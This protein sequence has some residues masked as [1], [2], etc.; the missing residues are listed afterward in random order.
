MMVERLAAALARTD[1]TALERSLEGE[2][3]HPG[4]PEY[5]RSRRLFNA[6]V[7][8][9]PALI[10][11]CTGPEDV[12]LAVGF[13]RKHAVPLS[14]K[15]GGHGVSGGALCDD[16]ITLD[17][18]L[19]DEVEV[20]EDERRARCG[21]GA[22]WERLND[23]AL[24]RGLV[25]AG[26]ACPSVG[27]AGSTLGGGLGPLMGRYGLSC[28][29]LL[30]AE[31]VTS[32]GETVRASR[33][34]ERELLWG[35]RGGGGN[36]GAVTSMELRLHPADEVYGGAVAWPMSK[37]EEVL[38]AFRRLALR[39]PD[40]LSVDL[41]LIDVP[42]LGPA[43]AGMVCYLGEAAEA[44]RALQPLYRAG[45]PDIDGLEELDHRRLGRIVEDTVPRGT[46][47]HWRAG[48]LRDLDAAVPALLREFAAVPSDLTAIHLW[49]LHGAAARV[50]PDATAFPHRQ[51]Q[52]GVH[53]MSAW[54]HPLDNAR[55][56]NWTNAVFEELRPHLTGG[57]YANFAGTAERDPRTLY[58]D[59]LA[60]LS[61]LKARYDPAGLFRPDHEVLASFPT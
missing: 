33:E 4:E 39:M 24:E 5:E 54:R 21:P 45:R 32:A 40:E 61:E 49:Y 57:S 16:G 42:L 30:R 56:I 20:D 8:R 22:T 15:G 3:L 19:M 9:R 51:P 50:P 52:F 7:D 14:V 46:M 2:V 29:N 6:M 47:Q 44:E 17:M 28:D 34:E 55:N 43:V 18:G 60:R 35:L 10:V 1:I 23:L 41:S 37:G 27:V 53:I 11:R 26:G 58:G 25:A 36:L 12:A 59:N 38:R 13:A 48:F 31:V